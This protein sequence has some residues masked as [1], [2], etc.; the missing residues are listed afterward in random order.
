MIATLMF[1]DI[2]EALLASLKLKEPDFHVGTGL[3]HLK[4]ELDSK[5]EWG[6]IQAKKVQLE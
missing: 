4:S 3:M 1:E 5:S 6:I 2:S